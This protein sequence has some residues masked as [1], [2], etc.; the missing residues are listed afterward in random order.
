MKTYSLEERAWRHKRMRSRRR[1]LKLSLLKLSA[2]C[3]I[4]QSTLSLY[5]K[6]S[7]VPNLDNFKKICKA[8]RISANNLIGI[9]PK[10]YK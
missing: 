1:E 7:R 6:G 4:A 9:Q 5:E 3:S 10:D 2:R 8:L